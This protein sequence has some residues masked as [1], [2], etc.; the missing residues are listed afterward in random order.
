MFR[1]KSEFLATAS[2]ALYCLVPGVLLTSSPARC[3]SLRPLQPQGLP[4]PLPNRCKLSPTS[5]LQNLPP[6]PST[7]NPLSSDLVM[8]HSLSFTSLLKCHLLKGFLSTPVKVAS[9]S[10]QPPRHHPV[11]FSSFLYLVTTFLPSH[12]VL[13]LRRGTISNLFGAVFSAPRV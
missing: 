13:S 3:L 12:N 9:P 6:P 1:I 7:K 5:Q 10:H 4:P 8:A 11:L 2:Q